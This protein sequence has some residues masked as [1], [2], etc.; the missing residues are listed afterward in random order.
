[1]FATRP[2]RV[3]RS[4]T[5]S[6]LGN[7][8]RASIGSSSRPYIKH[9]PSIERKAPR[10]RN[11]HISSPG[12]LRR[13]D[14]V[15]SSMTAYEY[16]PSSRRARPRPGPYSHYHPSQASEGRYALHSH[17]SLASLRGHGISAGT[18]SPYMLHHRTGSGHHFSRSISPAMSN[19]Y[20]YRRPARYGA[21]RQGSFGT[22][23]S[24]PTSRSFA[25]GCVQNYA[26]EYDAPTAPFRLLPSPAISSDRYNSA[27]NA[28]TTRMA[29]PNYNIPRHR[30]FDSA[31]SLA[32]G[33]KSP[34]DS[35]VPFYYDYSES[36]HGGETPLLLP[37]PVH[38]SIPE[39]GSEHGEHAG[40]PGPGSLSAH[41]PFGMVSGSA[42][43]PAELP[44]A[45]NRRP[46]EQSSQSRHS[47]KASSKSTG[48]QLSPPLELPAENIEH[49]ADGS[50]QDPKGHETQV[51]FL[52]SLKLSSA[53]TS[54]TD[55][56]I[57][58]HRI[59]NREW[60]AGRDSTNSHRNW[61]S[62][63]SSVFFT[64]AS[65]S[66]RNLSDLAARAHS[67]V[68]E[69]ESKEIGSINSIAGHITN[70]HQINGQNTSQVPLDEKFGLPTF[71]FRPLSIG[72]SSV[73][74]PL[75]SPASPA[76]D[77]G[78]IVSPRPERPT[79]S[80][81]RLRF[82]KI[83]DMDQ[84][85]IIEPLAKWD[86]TAHGSA[87]Q[88]EPVSEVSS[89]I[90]A[91]PQQ[92]SCDS[93]NGGPDGKDTKP[94][95]GS[96]STWSDF[97]TRDESTVDSLLE[98]HIECLGLG[99]GVREE[100]EPQQ[101]TTRSS[102]CHDLIQ[103]NDVS[104]TRVIPDIPDT[105]STVQPKTKGNV[106]LSDLQRPT[107]LS[108]F[109]QQLLIPKR[110]FA[111]ADDTIHPL[112]RSNSDC[113]FSHL[114][115]YERARP[116]Y[117]WLSLPSDSGL[118]AGAEK[119]RQ[120]LL[121]GDYAD[122]ESL[123]GKKSETCRQPNPYL[124]PEP[125][126]KNSR[127]SPKPSDRAGNLHC[128][129]SKSARVSCQT[130]HQR[131]RLRLYLKTSTDTFDIATSD[132][133]ISTDEK[134]GGSGQE[135]RLLNMTNIPVSTV[136]GFAELSGQ[137]AN[138]SQRSLTLALHN[139]QDQIPNNVSDITPALPMPAGRA[140]GLKKKDSIKTVRSQKSK[141]SIVDPINH[142]RVTSRRPSH[143]VRPQ[144][145]V[146][147]LAQP[148]LGPL[149]RASQF[150]LTSGFRN[151]T[152]MPKTLSSSEPKELLHGSPPGQKYV[153]GHRRRR[154]HSLRHII[155][156][157]IRGMGLS[158]EEI[159]AQDQHLAEDHPRRAYTTTSHH[160]QPLFP[161]TEAMSNFAY[162]KHKLRERF[163]EW[164]DRRCFLR[165]RKRNPAGG[166][167]M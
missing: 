104:E 99:L 124:P 45:H 133:W 84:A 129:R 132:E 123:G 127:Y 136:D 43:A 97:T 117:G 34:V 93:A 26:A 87:I 85:R 90:E 62:P 69:F 5:L 23:P 31:T 13:S 91:T 147:Q 82:S 57:L 52:P 80:E 115:T 19:L 77:M 49:Q 20:E 107:S 150:D 63:S 41:T 1:M 101:S 64:S 65:R 15:R 114:R 98:R 88:L 67:P 61:P 126:I 4:I 140:V 58:S 162:C 108:T 46:S 156:G 40:R 145:S 125:V 50:Q 54:K 14:T 56:G 152:P 18:P 78:G 143:D 28:S 32:S 76:Q 70:P 36:F 94:N 106:N 83:L 92:L 158:M 120:T 110:L 166:F 148:D 71:R 89:P 105:P 102:S 122:I 11:N 109:T 116:S 139:P 137:S 44:T 33:P 22:A 111:D 8:S 160:E 42:F 72:M 163:R 153:K 81:S 165:R 55:A 7:Q 118:K 6:S 24:S 29:T 112:S 51:S 39:A 75:T 16:G 66:P 35:I 60:H 144:S 149:L 155:P 131:R 96:K 9:A 146:P 53:D 159:T 135:L 47:R 17:R 103:V 157:S 30:R 128:Y 74:R 167:L 142:S 21:S 95:R 86:P 2:P 27:R 3:P 25:R 138:A 59:G 37:V 68:S 48:S 79:S 12:R 161:E 121:S 134:T 38:T 100:P 113:C 151:K 130:S 154:F 73:S 164:C 10:I 119:S 141:Q